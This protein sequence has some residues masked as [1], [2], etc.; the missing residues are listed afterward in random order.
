MGIKGLAEYFICKYAGNEE[1]DLEA[2]YSFGAKINGEK[3]RILKDQLILAYSKMEED[4]TRLPLLKQLNK[5]LND[6]PNWDEFHRLMINYVNY[7]E[8][9][10]LK[11]VYNYSIKLLQ[12]LNDL[13]Y[14]IAQD[15][16]LD[17]KEAFKATEAIKIIQKTTWEE[18]KRLLNLHDIKGVLI[19]LPEAEA[20]LDSSI[21]PTWDYGPGKTPVKERVMTVRKHDA[22]KLMNKLEDDI[23]YD[24][25]RARLGE[26]ASQ[27]RLDEYV[28]NIKDLKAQLK[29]QQTVRKHD[30]KRR[31]TGIQRAKEDEIKKQKE[32]DESEEAY[33]KKVQERAVA[34]VRSE[35]IRQDIERRRKKKEEKERKA[36]EEAEAK[37]EFIAKLLEKEELKDLRKELREEKN[38]VKEKGR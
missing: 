13:R 7:V 1:A 15:R 5:D 10:D 33:R 34:R 17:K 27:E 26:Y 9:N 22:K 31:E 2:D 14:D 30:L 19:R 8:F 38:K 28:K 32:K 20:I 6:Y 18:S 29:R 25:A 35:E 4:V 16:T 11:K 23:L 21:V 3:V 12:K 24:E 37:E 36:R